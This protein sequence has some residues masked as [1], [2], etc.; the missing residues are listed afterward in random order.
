M[1]AS[2]GGGADED[3]H[4]AT[5]VSKHALTRIEVCIALVIMGDE[6]QG[7]P[8]NWSAFSRH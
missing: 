6:A 4:P 8:W 5:I 2:T 7:M 3:E 1:P